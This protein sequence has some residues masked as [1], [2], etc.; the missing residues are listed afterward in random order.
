M[1]DS[2]VSLQDTRTGIA[3]SGSVVGLEGSLVVADVSSSSGNGLR[4]TMQLRIDG[5]GRTG[6]GTIRAAPARGDEE[7]HR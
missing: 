7:G 1:N 2:S 5:A 6:G 4:L 3:Y